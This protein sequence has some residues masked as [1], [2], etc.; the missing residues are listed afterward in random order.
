MFKGPTPP[1]CAD[2]REPAKIFSYR[3][4]EGRLKQPLLLLSL[5]LST[6]LSRPRFDFPA[7]F[8]F[9]YPPLLSRL[10]LRRAK[11]LTSAASSPRLSP[12]GRDRL[13]SPDLDFYGVEACAFLDQLNCANLPATLQL[14]QATVLD[15]VKNPDSETVRR[16]DGSRN[17]SY[18]SEDFLL[19]FYIMDTG[20]VSGRSLT[21][22]NCPL[23]VGF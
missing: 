12:L 8:P 13:Y 16:V 10:S 9:F 7:L 19:K 1:F 6:G 4:G 23:D 2:D 14:T 5:S 17:F 21:C 20:Q 11:P 18:F 22:N 15:G 3:Q